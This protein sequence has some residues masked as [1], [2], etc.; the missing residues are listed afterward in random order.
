MRLAAA[1][2]QGH[3]RGHRRSARP[4]HDRQHRL[5]LVRRRPTQPDSQVRNNR[6]VQI[7]TTQPIQVPG[8]GPE[9]LVQ[10]RFAPAPI[11]PEWVIAGRPEARAVE[12]VRSP[13]GTC[14]S[15]QW[16]CTAG[17]FHWFFFVEET[18]HILE[19]EVLVRRPGGGQQLLRAGDVAV[20]PANT[21]MVWHVETYVRKLAV[22]RFPVPRPFGRAVRMLQ[23]LRTRLALRRLPLP[24]VHLSAAFLAL[25][26]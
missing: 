16:D 21:W 3:P 17:T 11:R 24:P 22:C 4:G 5:R 25:P 12:L 23:Q 7:S 15:A 10:D 6:C 18:V 14:T 20:M 8:L 26:L 9:P 2:V 13:D 19:G 1:P